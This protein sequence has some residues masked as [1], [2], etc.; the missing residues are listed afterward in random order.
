MRV[1]TE[2]T[3]RRLDEAGPPEDAQSQS[4]IHDHAPQKLSFVENVIL[5]IKVLTVAAVVLAA[6][7]GINVWTSS[8]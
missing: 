2:T 6:L 8:K 1:N 7:W 3:T 4:I 5:T